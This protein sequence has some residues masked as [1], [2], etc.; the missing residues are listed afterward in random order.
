MSFP[1]VSSVRDLKFQ[2]YDSNEKLSQA[3]KKL[4]DLQTDI[5]RL[6]DEIYI[7]KSKVNKASTEL[8]KAIT[9]LKNP[10]LYR[11]NED[12]A[13]ILRFN[14]NLARGELEE[15]KKNVIDAE[16]DLTNEVSKTTPANQAYVHYDEKVD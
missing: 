6:K 9:D 13:A 4:K 3:R 2:V 8:A 15:A 12:D 16:K 10:D 7:R 11:L 5:G 14:L 1:Q